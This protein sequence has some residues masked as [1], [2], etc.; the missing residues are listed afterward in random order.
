VVA[1][2]EV[3]R[4][5]LTMFRSAEHFRPMHGSRPVIIVSPDFIAV[6]TVPPKGDSPLMSLMRATQVW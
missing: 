4:L 2:S 5:V 6:L 1:P 3:E